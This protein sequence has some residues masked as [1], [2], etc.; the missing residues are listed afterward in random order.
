M[1]ITK[2][3]IDQI[4][5]DSSSSPVKLWRRTIRRGHAVGATQQPLPATRH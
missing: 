4:Q 1:A 3:W 5:R 2:G